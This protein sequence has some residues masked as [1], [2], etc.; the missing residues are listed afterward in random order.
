[1]RRIDINFKCLGELRFLQLGVISTGET[2]LVRE[3]RIAPHQVTSFEGLMAVI[4]GEKCRCPVF[5]RMAKV[6]IVDLETETFSIG[7][8]SKDI[9]VVLDTGAYRRLS[10][11]L[12][13]ARK[14]RPNKE[15]LSH[16]EYNHESLETARERAWQ[17][18]E[19]RLD[20]RSG[21][22]GKRHRSGKRLV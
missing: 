11:L 7:W 10:E 20:H 2:T 13:D 18:Q 19:E 8:S 3:V 22:K 4:G 21:R 15:Y 16:L 17:F 1:M 14:Y 9:E 12:R 5:E 6:L